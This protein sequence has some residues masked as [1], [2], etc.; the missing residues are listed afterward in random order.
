MVC[1]SFLECVFAVFSGSY[2]GVF[3][4]CCLHG[5]NK[6]HVNVFVPS[7]SDESDCTPGILFVCQSRCVCV[8]A[9]VSFCVPQW[10]WWPTRYRSHSDPGVL[11]DEK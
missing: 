2:C 7:G 6:L 8:C 10:E 11:F 3:F 1:V 9:R 5:D 4:T